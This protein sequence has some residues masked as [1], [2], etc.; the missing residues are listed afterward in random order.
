MVSEENLNILIIHLCFSVGKVFF[1]WLLPGYCIFC[2]FKAIYLGVGVFVG[3]FWCFCVC[4]FLFLF[5]WWRVGCVYT[6]LI[7]GSLS[8]KKIFLS[9][10][11]FT[12]YFTICSYLTVLGY[13]VEHNVSLYSLSFSVWKIS[14]YSLTLR[15][16]SSTMSAFFHFCYCFLF[17]AYF[18]FE[19]FHFASCMLSTL[20]SRTLNICCFIFFG[21]DKLNISATSG[22]GRL[23]CLFR[24]CFLPFVMS[25]NFPDSQTPCTR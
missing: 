20:F 4:L 16:I 13:F 23:L 25:I 5:F 1:L 8:F 15:G 22:F 7:W 12:L 19:G 17:L 2:C 24:L 11:I 9:L 10:V 14:R 18:F 6:M 21:H 3:E